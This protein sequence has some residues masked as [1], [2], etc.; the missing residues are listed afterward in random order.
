MLDTLQ[1]NFKCSFMELDL[2]SFIKCFEMNRN[3]KNFVCLNVYSHLNL[4]L[5]LAEPRYV[6]EKVGLTFFQSFPLTS[7]QYTPAVLFFVAFFA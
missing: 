4:H 5:T 7:L 6:M 2:I 3:L 1:A